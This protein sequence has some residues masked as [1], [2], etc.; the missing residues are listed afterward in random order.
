MGSPPP[1]A[2]HQPRPRAGARSAPSTAGSPAE[3]AESPIQMI[4]PPEINLPKGS[5]AIRGLAER[6]AAT[7]VIGTGSM[8]EPIANSA[9]RSGFGPELSLCYDSGASNGPFGS[10]GAFCYQ[11]SPVRGTRGCDATSICRPRN[12]T[13]MCSC[14]PAPKTFFRSCVVK[15]MAI[16]S[17]MPIASRPSMNT[18]STAT[19]CGST[20][21][22][23]RTQAMDP[24][25]RLSK[26][27]DRTT[28]RQGV[29]SISEGNI[30]TI[31][32]A[33]TN[34]R[35]ADQ[36]QP[37]RIFSWQICG[38]KTIGA[39][40]SAA[41]LT[42]TDHGHRPI[43]L[44]SGPNPCPKLGEYASLQHRRGPLSSVTLY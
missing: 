27:R 41:S 10:A 34:S 18:R 31:S 16:W 35:I 13:P 43:D 23:N 5:G 20:G 22:P 30:L 38:P 3:A 12:R 26:A 2:S 24:H 6:L 19:S 40:A 33:D 14:S 42:T 28:R 36:E 29:R 17:R 11:R 1:S 44:F 4:Q 8:T 37:E 39:T 25:T 15:P 9:G 7:H 21:P 32:S